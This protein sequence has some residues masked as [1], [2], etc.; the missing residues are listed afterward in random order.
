M[1]HCFHSM[2][3]NAR[4]MGNSS[5]LLVHNPIRRATTAMLL[6]FTRNKGDV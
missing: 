4:L 3:L 6:P 5:L 2:N 1:Q